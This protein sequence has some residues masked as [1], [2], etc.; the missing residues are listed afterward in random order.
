MTIKLETAFWELMWAMTEAIDELI[1]PQVLPLYRQSAISQIKGG[2]FIAFA[3]R[4]APEPLSYER[5]RLRNPYAHED[6]F[7]TA[8]QNLQSA[9]YLTQD[10]IATYKAIHEYGSLI[11]TQQVAINN[12]SLIDDNDM[13][14]LAQYLYQIVVTASQSTQPEP[15]CMRDALYRK[16]PPNASH[17]LFVYESI[18]QLNAFRDYCHHAA[19]KPFDISGH[20]W[21]LLSYMWSKHVKTPAQM[22]KINDLHGYDETAYQLAMDDLV[23]RGWVHQ[24]NDHYQLTVSGKAVRTQVEKTTNE[25]FYR[26]FSDLNS[27]QITDM[28]RLILQTKTVVEAQTR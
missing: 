12:I 26:T 7:K 14:R 19:W 28:H 25:Y 4:Y 27:N 6:F 17:L 22:A 3:I 13:Q 10:N 2:F 11:H 8:I 24:V 1:L 5:L 20:T 9:D 21:E 23:K 18:W 16:P 15:K